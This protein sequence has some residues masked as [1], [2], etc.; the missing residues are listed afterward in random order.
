MGIVRCEP[1]RRRYLVALRVIAAL[2]HLSLERQNWLGQK[3]S[4]HCVALHEVKLIDLGR[5]Q[6]WDPHNL[7]IE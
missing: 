6:L 3:T 7:R 2:F 4:L 1:D 5:L